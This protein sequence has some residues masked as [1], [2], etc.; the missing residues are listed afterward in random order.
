GA[1]RSTKAKT[2][3]AP[4]SPALSPSSTQSPPSSRRWPSR[5]S[6]AA[7]GSK[8]PPGEEGGSGRE[9]R[10]DR[11]QMSRPLL[12]HPF[13]H[14]RRKPLHSFRRELLRRFCPV[15]ECRN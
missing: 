2:Q 14:L 8:S 3:T 15:T 1:P 7:G 5:T 4:T 9:L 13:L 10:R 6:F 12:V 11:L